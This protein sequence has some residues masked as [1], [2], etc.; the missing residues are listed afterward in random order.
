MMGASLTSQCEQRLSDDT[1]AIAYRRRRCVRRYV[2]SL[3]FAFAIPGMAPAY[4]EPRIPSGDSVVLE[5][6]PGIHDKSSLALRKL[7]STLALDR[8][9]LELALKVARLDIDQSRR[10][11]DPRFLGRAEAALAPWPEEAD[12][13]PPE[14]RLLHAVIMQSN[15][16]FAGSI[17]ALE[18]V[19]AARPGMAQGWLTLAAVHHAQANYPAALHDCGQVAIGMLGLVP[20]VCTAS[21]MSLVGRAPLAL[22]AVGISLAQNALE[23]RRQPAVAVWALSMQA[24]TADR[25]G[26]PSAERYFEQAL[27]VDNSDPYVLGAWSDWLLDHGRPQDVI[28]LLADYTRI[29]PLLLRLAIAEQAAGDAR[30]A[31]SVAE[32]ATRFEASRLRGDTVHRREE[33]RFMLVLQHQA[34]AALELAKANWTVQREPADARILLETAIAAHR[35][36]AAGPVQAWLRDNGVEDIRLNTL[37]AQAASKARRGKA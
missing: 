4:A 10:L 18:R 32:L 9:D 19:V 14:A 26:D 34:P 8:H 7:N 36:E 30:L 17:E 1:Q 25:I 22:H 2:R 11:G 29:D 33:A 27:A 20:D 28:H 31:G 13:T 12:R 37:A 35:P 21:V 16:D 15:H 23:A 5:Q 6:V 3:L 24:E